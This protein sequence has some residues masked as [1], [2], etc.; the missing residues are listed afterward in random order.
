M[1]TTLEL[2]LDEI[3]EHPE[4]DTLRL[5]YADELEES[6]KPARAALIRRQVTGS[7]VLPV[8]ELMHDVGGSGFL[9][10][11]TDS[12]LH[13]RRPEDFDNLIDGML[14]DRQVYACIDRGFVLWVK[15]PWAWWAKHG[16]D[17]RAEEWVPK[18]RFTTHPTLDGGHVRGLGSESRQTAIFPIAGQNVHVR[19]G[20]WAWSELL[21]LRWP[22]TAF[23]L[24]PPMFGDVVNLAN[25]S[26]TFRAEDIEIGRGNMAYMRPD[27]EITR[28]VAAAQARELALLYSADVI[29]DVT[30][31][32]GVSIDHL[33]RLEPS[34][35]VPDRV[36]CLCDHADNTPEVLNLSSRIL[37]TRVAGGEVVREVRDARCP[38]CGRVYFTVSLVNNEPNEPVAPHSG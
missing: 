30:T 23:E 29:H 35:S 20:E 15:C 24:P 38:R 21:P 11:T 9:H 25:R 6:G 18:V 14:T 32:H 34:T 22:G 28:A 12:D 27:P 1:K 17:L 3:K 5:A 31:R 10:L 36:E 26:Y 19:N 7:P 37:R 2:L 8:Y 13:M 4:D 33:H 16:D